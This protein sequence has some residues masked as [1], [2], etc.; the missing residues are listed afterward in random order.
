MNTQTALILLKNSG[1]HILGTDG[2]FI[3]LEDPSCILRSFETFTEYAWVFI[4]FITGLL[5]FGWAVSLIRGVK[6]DLMNNI[7]NLILIFGT[8]TVAV[9]IINLIFGDDLFARGCKTIRVS[10]TE[11]AELLAAR[12]ARLS[13]YQGVELYDN[14][15][16]ED[17]G[18][19]EV[20]SV[21]II[22]PA[23]PSSS[24]QAPST[25]PAVSG[26]SA[27]Q[28]G[29]DV[30]YTDANGGRVRRTGGT[31]A[32][33]NN[34][35]GNIRDSDFARRMGA[36]GA[37]NG[38]AVFPDEATGLAAMGA[39]LRGNSY[40]NLSIIDAIS[41]YAPPSENDTRAYQQRIA[42]L[43]GLDIQLRIRDLDESQFSALLGAMRRIEGWTPGREIRL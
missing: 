28:S 36:I 39:L 37:A 14:I 7:K 25:P 41:R 32:W 33:R 5:L 19:G 3:Y 43:T 4:S 9:P 10:Y 17:S 12:N 13:S 22:P 6:N 15:D 31:P 1:F 35:P 27:V 34:N 8:L 16:I 11:I 42:Q 18:P 38:F 23:I 30:I 21:S 2:S 26:V 20:A 29:R 24:S 40:R